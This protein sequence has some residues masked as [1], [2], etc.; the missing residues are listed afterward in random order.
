MV[1]AVRSRALPVSIAVFS[2]PMS[3]LCGSLSS[4]AS[5]TSIQVRFEQTT[6][7]ASLTKTK[8]MAQN[9]ITSKFIAVRGGA[10]VV[11]IQANQGAGYIGSEVWVGET[12]AKCLCAWVR[13]EVMITKS[14]NLLNLPSSFGSYKAINAST[15][16]MP[17][18]SS[19]SPASSRSLGF[20]AAHA[21]LASE[22]PAWLSSATN[23][24]IT[25]SLPS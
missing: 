14:R 18:R 5:D 22:P 6:H 20:K 9:L 4:S 7:L 12:N 16:S 19:R 11:R 15:A 23:N 25:R 2:S 17:T 13:D 3:F 21:V 24:K 10:V 1:A 8:Q